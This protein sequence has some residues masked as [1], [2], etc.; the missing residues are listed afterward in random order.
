MR[1]T[2]ADNSSARA[3][4]GW[5]PRVSVEEGIAKLLEAEELVQSA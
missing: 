1:D 3:T 2:L 4:L 5:I